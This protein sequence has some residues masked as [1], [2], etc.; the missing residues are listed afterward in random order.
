MS[1]CWKAIMLDCQSNPNSIAAMITKESARASSTWDSDA[2]AFRRRR[3]LTRITP[4]PEGQSACHSGTIEPPTQ[5]Q[6][7][8][9]L[10][11]TFRCWVLPEAQKNCSFSPESIEKTSRSSDAAQDLQHRLIPAG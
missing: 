1:S 9:L 11:R 5:L 2:G 10:T 3:N 4:I 8:V 7:Y 6:Q